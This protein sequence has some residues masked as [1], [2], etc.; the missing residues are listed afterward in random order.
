MEK[1]TATA[2][3]VTTQ[4][5]VP[6][7]F[8]KASDLDTDEKFA[9]FLGT[10][11]PV[12]ANGY[13]SGMVQFCR[14]SGMMPSQI[15]VLDSEAAK[16]LVK[17]FLA[18][19]KATARPTAGKHK[20]GDLISVN[21]IPT[22]LSQVQ[23]FMDHCEID[24]PSGTWKKIKKGLPE[25]V[26]NDLRAHYREEIAKLMGLADERDRVLVILPVAS[27]IREAGLSELAAK[28]IFII[29][30]LTPD[31]P[32]YVEVK[33]KLVYGSSGPVPQISAESKIMTTH[34]GIIIWIRN[35][36][37]FFSDDSK[38][39]PQVPANSIGMIKVYGNSKKAKYISFMTPE[40][41]AHIF[42][43]LHYRRIHHEKL[44]INSPIIRDKIVPMSRR[45]NR[46]RHI[47]PGS[48][49]WMA[50]ELLKRAALP[51]EEL[52][53]LHGL[54]KFFDTMAKNAGIDHMYKE[55]FMGHSV[56][57]DDVYYDIENPE[58]LYRMT[59]EYMKAVDML[60]IDPKYRLQKENIELKEKLKDAPKLEVL[61][62]DMISK[63]L[64]V[65]ALK[66][67]L[68]EQDRRHKENIDKKVDEAVE[69]KI[70]EIARRVDL[71]KLQR[72]T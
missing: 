18:H 13:H 50:R 44:T 51:A 20:P 7:L 25:T 40:A 35:V 1:G 23:S 59:T 2:E 42:E 10:L 30:I 24:I 54:R 26:E 56:K 14:F 6:A 57:L 21:S 45:V 41:L 19:M 71:T 47:Q 33:S 3:I 38:E 37:A 62:N 31:D 69:K 8:V 66:R 67:R 22:Y 60:T 28:H 52:Q 55:K 15:A 49:N 27:G 34:T 53:P 43:D 65:D 16:S 29:T 64:E 70:Q 61:Q 12:T 17:R 36:L 68:E 32:Q 4:P 5:L 39:V 58:S 48:I 63:S 9:E 11:K 46:A 72:P